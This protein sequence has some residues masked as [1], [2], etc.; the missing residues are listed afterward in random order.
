MLKQSKRKNVKMIK[1][2]KCENGKN[3]QMGKQ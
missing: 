2:Q 3:A 1:T